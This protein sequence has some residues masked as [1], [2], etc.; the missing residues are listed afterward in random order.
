MSWNDLF[1]NSLPL[2]VRN[3]IGRLR[4]YL[5]SIESNAEATAVP[6]FVLR[7]TMCR[8]LEKTSIT[9]SYIY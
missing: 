3:Q 2:S 4:E 8:N 1:K 5:A 9:D 6:A 7:G